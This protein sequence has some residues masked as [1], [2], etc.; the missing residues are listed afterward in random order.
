MKIVACVYSTLLK[1]PKAHKYETT[2]HSHRLRCGELHV[3]PHDGD[4]QTWADV[5]SH[6]SSLWFKNS[7][8]WQLQP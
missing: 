5:T 1:L 7:V 2:I 8:Q 4:G 6:L 3:Q